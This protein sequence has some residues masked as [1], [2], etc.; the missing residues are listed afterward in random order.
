VEATPEQLPGSPL[1]SD[2][3]LERLTPLGTIRPTT[4]GE[5]LFREGDTTYDFIVILDGRVAIVEGY[6]RNERTLV[7]GGARE[8]VTE[9]NMFTGERLFTTAIVRDAGS[10]LVVPMRDVVALVGS[11][12]ELGDRIVN[13]VF[14]R[15]EWLL[16]QRTGFRIVG[17]RFSYDTARLREF[18]ARNR[19]VHVWIDLDQDPAA[20]AILADAKIPVADTPVVALP[21]G[22]LLVNPSNAE[23]ARAVGLPTSPEPETVYDMI[24]VGAGPAG[25]AA[26]VYSSS[27]GN[28]VA[29]L[30]AVGPGGQIGTTTRFE[31][32]LGFP[33]GITGKEFAERA[34][35]Q[36]ERF[37]ADLLVPSRATALED[38]DGLDVVRTDDGN[39]VVG[40]SVVIA[41]GVDYRRLPVAGIE[42]LEGVSVFYSPL[43]EEERVPPGAPIV[44]VGGGNSA[45][46]AA[47]AAAG[48]GHDVT[49]VVRG[50]DLEST[51]VS[52]LI[53]RIAREP[54]IRVLTDTEVIE[55]VGEPDLSE[56]V[57]QNNRSGDRTTVP[58]LAMFVLIGAAPYTT[59]LRD[60][61]ELDRAGFVLTGTS[62]GTEPQRHE[63]WR[64]LGRG[65]MLLETSRPGVFAVGDVRSGATNRVGSAVG[66]GSVAARLVHE[67][68]ATNV[69]RSR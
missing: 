3:D 4:V 23:L 42:R 27:E 54:T 32:Y 52:Y 8:F 17:S 29:V 26:A 63:P 15:R 11:V 58:A 50:P 49:L 55:V 35:V 10:I 16:R 5:V 56:V 12:P 31:N 22:A 41:T 57:V 6:G 69:A 43:A 33:V 14:A 19:L 21:S 44:V 13:T 40:R 18:A 1:L 37:G 65:P 46:Q 45:G 66:D 7:V 34:V 24:V 61:V 48:A 68:L 62:L 36:A 51:M 67:W 38:R 59:W 9:L 39:E 28:R 53:E 30:E 20:T 25:L 2:A 64:S 60:V 47:T